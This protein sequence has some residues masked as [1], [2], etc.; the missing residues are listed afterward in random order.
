MKKITISKDNESKKLIRFLSAYFKEAT[1]GFL[2]KMLRKKN[3]VLND[4]KALGSETLKEGDEISIYFSDETL[5]KFIGDSKELDI[6]NTKKILDKNYIIYED[7]NIIVINKPQGILSQKSEDKDISINEMALNYMFSNNE[8]DKESLSIFTP[9]IVNRLDRN[10][11]GLIIFAKK[12]KIARKLSDM[13]SQS[14]ID[15]YYITYS[16]NLGQNIFDD[17]DEFV[18]VSDYKKDEKNNMAILS[19]T[20]IY[21]KSINTSDVLDEGKIATKFKLL[22]KSDLYFVIEAMLYTG[23]SHQIRSQLNDIGLPIIGEVKYINLSD[24]KIKNMKEK[25]FNKIKHQVLFSNK[26]VFGD[27]NDEEFSYLNGKKFEI[28][29]ERLKLIT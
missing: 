9:S 27:F 29:Y 22:S 8:I 16:Y 26:I 21:D 13:F 10:T 14:R 20:H 2:Y 15:R 4:K 7:E 19:N 17:K 18:A 3:I 12:Y 24:S 1:T 6:S 23:K 11:G 28:D 5:N 25:Y